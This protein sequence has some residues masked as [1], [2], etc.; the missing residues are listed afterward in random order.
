MITILETHLNA[1]KTA[2]DLMVEAG[3]QAAAFGM[4]D[5][6]GALERTAAALKHGESLA[7]ALAE[8][9]KITGDEKLEQD[10]AALARE[11]GEV[12]DMV[13]NAQAAYENYGMF[14]LLPYIGIGDAA[15]EMFVKA[16]SVIEAV[17]G[18]GNSALAAR[19]G[20]LPLD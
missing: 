5:I 9:V 17:M 10:V 11:R 14:G 4:S 18:S 3:G 8:I 13:A 15:R 1:A 6:G 2:S 20:P 16:E 19:S 7:S 12:A